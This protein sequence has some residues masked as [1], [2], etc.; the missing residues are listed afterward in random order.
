MKTD[1][2]RSK[3]VIADSFE[4]LKI[5]IE[6]KGNEGLSGL[7][8]AFVNVIVYCC[9]YLFFMR[10]NMEYMGMFIGFMVA[11]VITQVVIRF[12]NCLKRFPTFPR[13]RFVTKKKAYL[14][15]LDTDE[16]R[17][18]EYVNEYDKW[19]NENYKDRSTETDLFRKIVDLNEGYRKY[20]F[21][22]L[23]NDKDFLSFSIGKA[24]RE[25]PVEIIYPTKSYYENDYLA[26]FRKKVTECLN[27]N[28]GSYVI[29]LLDY[30][31][32]SINY[33][34]KEKNEDDVQVFLGV[35]NS[36]ILDLSVYQSYE[37]LSIGVITDESAF[38]WTRFLPHVWSGN[39]RIIYQGNIKGENEDDFSRLLYECLENDNSTLVAFVD[40][41]FIIN[42]GLYNLF[43]QYQLPQNLKVIFFSKTGKCPSRAKLE[44]SYVGNRKGDNKGKEIEFYSYKAIRDAEGNLS[45]EFCREIAIKLSNINLIDSNKNERNEEIPE[46]LTLF[47]LYK[48]SS[49]D[50]F[51]NISEKPRTNIQNQFEVKVGL[52]KRKGILE[53]TILDLTNDGDGNHC[54]VTGTTGSGKSEFVLNYVLLACVKYSPED[55]SFVV[56][57]FKGGSMADKIKDLPH[58]K[59]VFSNIDGKIGRRELNRIAVLLKNEIYRREQILKKYGC[60]ELSDYYDRRNEQLQKQD[61]WQALPRLLVIV[62]E[63]SVFFAHDPQAASYI[64]EIAT[65]GRSVGMVLIL[66]TQSSSGV[67]PTQVKANVN[68]EIKFNSEDN[69]KKAQYLPKGRAFI[70]SNK[71]AEYECQMPIS[72]VYDSNIAS[73]SFMTISGKN[74]QFYTQNEKTQF[75][76]LH[77]CIKSK[78]QT[79]NSDDLVLTLPLEKYIDENK[80]NAYEQDVLSLADDI[81]NRRIEKNRIDFYNIRSFIV[82]G[83]HHMGK[84]MLAKKIVAALCDQ[85]MEIESLGIYVISNDKDNF[86]CFLDYPQFGDVKEASYENLFYV[87]L[88]LKREIDKRKKESQL[89]NKK[90]VIII[91]GCQDF[92]S[93]DNR[94]IT[95]LLE[96]VIKEADKNNIFIFLLLD[97]KLGYLLEKKIPINNYITF[98]MG[99]NYDYNSLG[100]HLD[101]IKEVPN[102]KGRCLVS[103]NESNKKTIEHQV[104]IEDIKNNETI[105]EKAKNCFECWKKIRRLTYCNRRENKIPTLED[106]MY[107]SENN[108]KYIPL[109]NN[110]ILLENNLECI[111]V[112]MDKYLLPA[113]WKYHK[114]KTYLVSYFYEEEAIRFT[115]YLINTFLR[116]LD[117]TYNNKV[118]NKPTVFIVGKID[119]IDVNNE[120]IR[121]VSIEDEENNELNKCVKG[122]IIVFFNYARA[123]FPIGIGVTKSKIIDIV[124]NKIDQGTIGIFVEHSSFMVNAK[125]SSEKLQQQLEGNC[126]GM[127]LGNMPSKHSFGADRLPYDL[128]NVVLGSGWG[129][130]ISPEVKGSKIVKI[131]ED[132]G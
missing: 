23:P 5:N 31:S 128:Q 69:N 108:L 58:C 50:G 121:Y 100:M 130:S 28:K 26:D 41:D 107:F 75:E 2:F 72:T 109:D 35:I 73:I 114:Y 98:Y 11:S 91:D 38:D 33:K 55:L 127:L 22:R 6:G 43:N 84:T 66:S 81:Y 129:V 29:S 112:G 113:F 63:V 48:T 82:Y 20:L 40:V 61:K 118:M 49:V 65:V 8:Q 46:R 71:K 54:L 32:V 51:R 90:L 117:K 37:E 13:I 34:V 47:E 131:V 64:T 3:R 52:G 19:S 57:D 94:D 44:I 126:C 10:N 122:D 36:I 106:N 120:R 77:D 78:W 1:F 111:P 30:N 123:L 103:L 59:G 119:I 7:L 97:N 104:L 17:I 83:Y 53:E 105:S 45:N 102:I 116:S 16:K 56:I 60:K 89:C 62:D 14:N 70:N 12:A 9:I 74:R 132:I 68:V 21:Y 27:G 86:S 110:I 115:T 18:R 95:P 67:I 79:Y 25:Y 125:C 85:S 39:R 124:L 88:F 93:N 92:I 87:L 42:H 99:E 96:Y 4:K 101:D 15:V 76:E 24:I 80:K